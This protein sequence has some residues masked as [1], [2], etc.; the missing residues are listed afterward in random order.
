MR[1]PPGYEDK[2]YPDYVCKLDKALYGL[3]QAPHAWYSRLSEKLERLR[4]VPSKADTSLFFYN[5]GKH[6]IY[7]DDIIVASSSMEATNAL[8]SDLHTQ[9]ALKDLGD[10]HY[11]LGMEVS[12]S[13]YGLLLKQER[14]ATELLKRARISACKSIGTPL[15]PSEK[16]LVS[17]GVSLG[18]QDVTQYKSIV[19]APQY[20]TLTKP[21][22]SFSMNKVCQFLHAP[23][24]V[25]WEAVKRILRYVK[26]TLRLGLKFVKDKSTI[27]GVFAN[28]D[29]AGFPNDRRSTEGFAVFFS[30]NLISW[31]AR[32]QATVSRLS[33]KQNTRHW[34]MELQK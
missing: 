2:L 23:T 24:I 33:T 16:L 3:K 32:K 19:A 14:Y 1:Q 13:G 7:V 18:P 31:S 10:L 28:A 8:I 30:L 4:F 9:F 34:Q 29:W 5:R 22:L 20:L 15:Q 26:G 27:V 21:D 12:R 17:N 25:H 6:T 11:F